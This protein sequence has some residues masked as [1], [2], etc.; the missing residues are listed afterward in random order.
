MVRPEGGVRQV[1]E[2][3]MVDVNFGAATV[4]Y[5]PAAKLQW[6][7]WMDRVNRHR[8]DLPDG[9]APAESIL[10]WVVESPEI[11]GSGIVAPKKARPGLF[12]TWDHGQSILVYDRHWGMTRHVLLSNAELTSRIVELDYQGTGPALALTLPGNDA[13]TVAIGLRTAD[14]S[15]VL[16]RYN[17]DI[18]ITHMH[19]VITAH[20]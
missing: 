4:V 20:A 13:R 17:A 8:D 18:H 1:T 11:F 5:S 14:P 19:D 2:R 9:A 16:D 15:A 10:A 12:A 7:Q 6:E 3:V